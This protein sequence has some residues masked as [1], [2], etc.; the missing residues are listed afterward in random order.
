MHLPTQDGRPGALI[1]DVDGTM[2]LQAPV[3]LRIAMKLLAAAATS[4]PDGLATVRIL[5][6]YRRAQ[7]SLRGCLDPARKGPLD[8]AQLRVAADATGE[9]VARVAASVERWMVREPLPLLARHVRVGLVPLLDAAS[10]AGIAIGV[11]SDYPAAEKLEALGVSR[12][13]GALVTAQ[14]PE[15]QRFKPDPRGLVV[16]LNR[17][18]VAADRAIYFGDRLDVDAVA[19]ERAGVAYVLVGRRRR[20]PRHPVVRDFEEARRLLCL[21]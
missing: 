21:E 9:P 5:R 13:I 15:V 11:V 19:A 1:F 12:Y 7:E 20:Q 4:P 18:G 14:D 8:D 3:R 2:Y 10:R 17:L 6:A 16:T